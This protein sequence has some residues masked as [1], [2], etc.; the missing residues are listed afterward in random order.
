MRVLHGHRA[1]FVPRG[2]RLLVSFDTVGAHLAPPPRIPWAWD[3]AQAAGWSHLGV[4]TGPV[5]P[6]L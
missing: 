5:L 2:P 1:V 3:L 4:M 6:A